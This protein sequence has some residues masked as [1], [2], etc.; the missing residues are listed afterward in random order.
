LFIIRFLNWTINTPA[1]AAVQWTDAIFPVPRKPTLDK[2][3]ISKTHFNSTQ[4]RSAIVTQLKAAS[5]IQTSKM[6]HPILGP[7]HVGYNLKL[8]SGHAENSHK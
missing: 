1:E 3:D 5:P 7:S 2:N 6:G 8:L 4:I